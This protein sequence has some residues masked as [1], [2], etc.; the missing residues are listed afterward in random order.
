MIR[1]AAVSA[2]ALLV[3]GLLLLTLAYLI[4]RG[5]RAVALPSSSE[6]RRRRLG[7]HLAGA[8]E[9]QVETRV[10]ET[11]EPAP[12]LERSP[13]WWEARRA[14]EIEQ[15]MEEAREW[16]ARARED[17]PARRIHPFG[18]AVCYVAN[19]NDA[20]GGW[21]CGVPPSGP[22]VHFFNDLSLAWEPAPD[23]LAARAREVL[24]G[25]S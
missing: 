10:T 19:H 20:S 8:L 1:L 13:E 11:R 17:R 24:G 2:L 6:M 22:V 4:L 9:E 12:A 3:P 25:A 7:T 15:R 18:W 23:W 5:R 14:A 21:L 16:I